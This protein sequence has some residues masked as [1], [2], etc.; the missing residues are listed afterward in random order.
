MKQICGLNDKL[1]LGQDGVSHKV[2]RLT[3]RAIVKNS[4]GLYALM[5]ADKIPAGTGCGRPGGICQNQIKREG[6][7]DSASPF[8][9][10]QMET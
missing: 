7:G 6:E 2:P 4:E 9:Y 1:I 10:I 5:Y 3:A 8:S